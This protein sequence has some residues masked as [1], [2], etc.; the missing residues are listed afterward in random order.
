MILLYF[1]VHYIGQNN[2]G[3]KSLVMTSSPKAPDTGEKASLGRPKDEG[4]RAA[5]LEAAGCLFMERGMS[6]T[7]M[8]AIALQ[9]GV[10]KLTVYNHFGNKE[11]LFVT[12]IREKC[13]GHT[14]EHIFEKLN[15]LD[16]RAELIHIGRAFVGL[17]YSEDAV[18]LHRVI[19]AEGQNNREMG[20][21][22]Y[23]AGPESLIGRFMKYLERV[24][25]FGTFAF[26]DKRVAAAQFFCLFK[27]E[28]H[29][30]ALL[31]VPPLPTQKELDKIVH[32]GV[33][34]FLRGYR[35][36]V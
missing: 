23:K 16:P 36:G 29:L 2:I 22:F 26:P 32:E 12:V 21:L 27:G 9:A 30:R 35:A 4:K 20:V 28:A 19:I 8:D 1:I 34:F 13:E 3:R 31:N 10:S 18:C 14:G 25:S 33:D 6:G 24:E 15:G 5:I 7:T 17:V 11:D